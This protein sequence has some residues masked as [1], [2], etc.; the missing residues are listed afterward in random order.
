MTLS[1]IETIRVELFEPCGEP[2][3][4]RIHVP[5]QN[6]HDISINP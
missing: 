2:S 6:Q 3:I 5:P 1:I 4:S